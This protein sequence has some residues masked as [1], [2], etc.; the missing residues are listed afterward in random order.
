[1]ATLMTLVILSGGFDLSVGAVV[2]LTGVAIAQLVDAGW[3]VW[4]ATAVGLA[5]GPLVGFTNSL[6]ITRVGINPLITTLGMLSIV[7]GLA[8]VLTGGLTGAILEEPFAFLGRGGFLGVPFP[9]VVFRLL[10]L[11]AWFALRVTPFGSRRYDV[12]ANARD[13]RRLWM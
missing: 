4:A 8:F 2:A 10:S 3:N 1:M 9:L 13:A 12:G 6:L 5:V 7:R 11:H